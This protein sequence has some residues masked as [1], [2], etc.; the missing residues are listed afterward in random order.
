MLDGAVDDAQHLKG[1]EHLRLI[2]LLQQEAGGLPLNGLT[3]NT[4]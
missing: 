2:A 3:I 4:W 1:R